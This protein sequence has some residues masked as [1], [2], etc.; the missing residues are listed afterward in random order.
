MALKKAPEAMPAERIRWLIV[1]TKTTIDF[2]EY[3]KIVGDD[4]N[5]AQNYAVWCYV[6]ILVFNYHV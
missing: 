2:V 6:P 4:P 5:E 1:K 3:A